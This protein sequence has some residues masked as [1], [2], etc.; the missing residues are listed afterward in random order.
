MTNELERAKQLKKTLENLMIDFKEAHSKANLSL[1]F[2]IHKRKLI[3]F[4]DLS[5]LFVIIKKYIT[6]IGSEKILASYI[7]DLKKKDK[8][9]EYFNLLH[10]KNFKT[11]K[12]SKTES[13]DWFYYSLFK[14]QIRIAGILSP[15]FIKSLHT[16]NLEPIKK[17]INDNKPDEAEI[18][19]ID[20]KEFKKLK[21]EE[22]FKPAIY[23]R[24]LNEFHKNIINWLDSYITIK[25]L[26][27]DGLLKEPRANRWEDVEIKFYDKYNINLII[28]GDE[29][30][31]DYEKLGFADKRQDSK[32]KA[33]YKKS[34]SLLIIFSIQNGVI[35]ENKFAKTKKEKE[36][37]KKDRLFLN[38]KL[39]EYFGLEDDPI[40]PEPESK[41]RIK[42]K[43]IPSP[44]FRESWQ[45]KNI[46]DNTPKNYLGDY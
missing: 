20:D 19:E 10:E 8:P 2:K 6:A 35:D 27:D 36:L 24:F 3:W 12:N 39:K 45:D 44:D 37:L 11:I 38:K 29:E 42:I 23:K 14:E 41:Y 30:K 25:E 16:K 31:S 34:W 13:Y 5:G 9:D 4:Y 1:K 15:V 22:V 33:S 28:N 21:T 46:F 17:I 43:L 26:A 40:I 7:T 18:K 32:N